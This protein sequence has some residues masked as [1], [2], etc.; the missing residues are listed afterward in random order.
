M[1]EIRG[2]ARDAPVVR[3]V[4]LELRAEPQGRVLAGYALRFGDLAP[5]FNES[6]APGSVQLAD[7]VNFNLSHKPFESIAHHPNGGLNV[8]LRSTGVHIDASI[9]PTPAGDHALEL[10]RSGEAT[11]LSIEFRALREEHSESGQRIIRNAVLSGIGLVADPAYPGSRAEAREASR[12]L[13][14]AQLPKSRFAA[15]ECIGSATCGK[16]LKIDPL[17]LASFAQQ[18]RDAATGE[19]PDV[20][21]VFKDYGKPV[22]SARRGGLRLDDAGNV[23]VNLPAGSSSVDDLVEASAIAGVIVRPLLDYAE[24]DFV[25]TLEGR[26]VFNARLRAFLIG[27]TDNRMGWDDAVILEEQR[28]RVHSESAAKRQRFQGL[29][30]ARGYSAHSDSSESSGNVIRR[31]PVQWL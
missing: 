12:R 28:H 1:M 5:D 14:R 13:L 31:R 16:A 9:P 6:F 23:S 19:G 30:K 20:L 26:T 21:A 29:W 15:C 8:D 24:A 18:I 3:D 17:A 10:V 11:G 2:Q 7:A 27:S 22:A 4:P 25:D